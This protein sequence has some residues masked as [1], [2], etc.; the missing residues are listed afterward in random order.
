M[1][2]TCGNEHVPGI[3]KSFQGHR[4]P[5]EALWDTLIWFPKFQPYFCSCSKGWP[6]CKLYEFSIYIDT[7]ETI[8]VF[9]HCG[10]PTRFLAGS[11][12]ALCWGSLPFFS[13]H[14]KSHTIAAIGI[15]RWGFPKIRVSQNGWFIKESPI[16]MDDLGVPLFLETPIWF[17]GIPT[18]SHAGMITV[19][20]CFTMSSHDPWNPWSK[21]V[22]SLLLPPGATTETGDCLWVRGHWVQ[23]EM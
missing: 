17:V 1:R 7:K 23:L 14:W 20:R 4:C 22:P 15:S 19:V 6:N 9:P 18:L 12:D 3:S 8:H 13:Q 11:F 10:V 5:F 2:W 21:A 16:K